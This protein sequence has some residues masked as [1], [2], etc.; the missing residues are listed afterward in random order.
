MLDQNLAGTMVR[1]S[2]QKPRKVIVQGDISLNSETLEIH[3]AGQP[4]PVTVTEFKLMRLFMRR[5]HVV[6]SRHELIA[7]LWT[8]RRGTTMRTVDN[9]VSK[10]REK[11]DGAGQASLIR[12][13]HGVGYKFVPQTKIASA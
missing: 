7:A 11:L 12:T 5:P 3:K 9:S 13:V 8:K 4:I 1:N 10:L 2:R 6:F